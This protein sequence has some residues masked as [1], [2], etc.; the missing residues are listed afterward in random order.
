MQVSSFWIGTDAKTAEPCLELEMFPVIHNLCQQNKKGVKVNS[1]HLDRCTKSRACAGGVLP[2]EPLCQCSDTEGPQW[3]FHWWFNCTHALK[4]SQQSC[5][6]WTSQP[7]CALVAEGL[8]G[9]RG[10][11]ERR[12]DSLSTRILFPTCWLDCEPSPAQTRGRWIVQITQPVLLIYNSTASHKEKNLKCSAPFKQ[13]ESPWW[14]AGE[15]VAC[16][17]TTPRCTHTPH[18]APESAHR[19]TVPARELKLQLPLPE[20]GAQSTKSRTSLEHLSCK[21]L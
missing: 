19:L 5:T 13:E 15:C 1:E 9:Q 11:A 3:W 16:F 14:Q 18:G 12:T 6:P 2:L 8:P 10:A 7:G 17:S 4:P 21:L 20:P